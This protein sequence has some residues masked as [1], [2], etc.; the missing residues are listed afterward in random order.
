MSTPNVQ[1]TL[2]RGLAQKD[3][4]FTPDLK[5][6]SSYLFIYLLQPTKW[7]RSRERK[8][9]H[10]D[11]SAH[12][13]SNRSNMIVMV[14]THAMDSVER[15]AWDVSILNVYAL[16]E[17]AARWVLWLE[18]IN[19]LVIGIL[20]KNRQD[21]SRNNSYTTT[22][23]EK[24]CFE[25]LI[26]TFD[27]LDRFQST[28]AIWY[29]WDN[30]RSK[31]SWTHARLDRIYISKELKPIATKPDYVIS[32][33][34]TLSDHLSVRQRISLVHIGKRQFPYVMNTSYVKDKEV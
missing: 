26:P 33:N 10:V 7:T 4:L 15:Y 25:L 11:I 12:P 2:W 22:E 3:T 27:V 32:E 9:L 28:N 23:E 13:T 5:T 6:Q 20:L 18:L 14:K 29:S 16:N 31:K 8:S 19:T 1:C 30:R 24:Q 21:K 17:A 34:S